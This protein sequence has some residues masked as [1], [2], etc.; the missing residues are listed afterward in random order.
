[1]VLMQI[2]MTDISHIIIMVSQCVSIQVE[3]MKDF[4]YSQM[5]QYHIGLVVEKDLSLIHL[6][7]VRVLLQICMLQH[8][9][10]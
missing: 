8:L 2:G 4:A 9:I 10:H 5:E 6:V 7:L 1:M 3:Q